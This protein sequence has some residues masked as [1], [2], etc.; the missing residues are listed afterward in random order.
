[1]GNEIKYQRREAGDRVQKEKWYRLLLFLDLSAYWSRLHLVETKANAKGKSI[2]QC[3]PSHK[4]TKYSSPITTLLQFIPLRDCRDKNQKNVRT[5]QILCLTLSQQHFE[6]NLWNWLSNW[7]QTPTPTRPG[8]HDCC[9]M[10][11]HSLWLCFLHQLCFIKSL[12]CVWLTHTYTTTNNT[13]Y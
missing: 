3:N 7:H 11:R 9:S 2:W 12:V 4:H 10:I 6:L 5:E 13:K 8:T 1:M